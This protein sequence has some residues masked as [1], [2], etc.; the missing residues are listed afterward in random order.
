MNKIVNCIS[1][2]KDFDKDL[3]MDLNIGLEIQDFINPNLL[4]EGW[5]GR[6][7]EYK[8][9]LDGFSNTLSLHGPFLDLKP[10]SPDSKIREISYKRY[11]QLLQ[12]GKELN[13]DYIIFH[14]QLNPWIK[15]DKIMELSYRLYGEFWNEILRQ[16]AD[17]KGVVLIENVFEPH[18]AIMRE[19]LDAIK[20]PNVKMC[21]DIG[22]ALLESKLGLREWV[23]ILNSRIEYIHLHWNEGVY[24]E[25][26]R[27]S[28]DNIILLKG[29]LDSF[30]LNPIIALEYKIHDL[31]GEVER[32]TNIVE[33]YNKI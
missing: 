30:N 12:I 23:E 19:L 24:D 7:E 20:L 4:D 29:I 31:K 32:I 18:P 22:H 21:L 25:H 14:S 27:P 8:S 5:E 17:F 15:E 9:V 26:N 10:I 16:V 6:L 2:M 28:T 13:A 11:L 33:N 1:N 3:Y